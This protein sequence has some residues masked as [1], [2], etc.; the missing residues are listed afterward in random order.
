MN[1]WGI[2]SAICRTSQK[3]KIRLVVQKNAT[4]VQRRFFWITK[5]SFTGEVECSLRY[6][7][8][9]AIPRNF[10]E[11]GTVKVR[12]KTDKGASW[13]RLLESIILQP[14]LLSNNR[15]VGRFFYRDHYA[16]CGWPARFKIVWHCI[17]V[18][19]RIEIDSRYHHA[20]WIQNSVIDVTIDCRRALPVEH[21]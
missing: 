7:A 12:K 20:I 17:A 8:G 15:H 9:M 16:S 11:T 13:N 3:S 2:Y 5:K 10:P 18:S 6:G 21:S 4:Q 19:V 1:G 14:I